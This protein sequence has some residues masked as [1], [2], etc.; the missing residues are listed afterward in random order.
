[1]PTGLNSTELND[2]APAWVS[3]PNGR[4][5]SIIF[6]RRDISSSQTSRDMEYPV[7][8][9]LYSLVMRHYR[10][11][12]ERGTGRGNHSSVVPSERQMG[13]HCHPRP[14]NSTVHGR[15]AMVLCVETAQETQQI[16]CG[17]ADRVANGCYDTFSE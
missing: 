13:Y 3:E 11:S 6:H 15:K 17:R 12:H 9:L 14:G 2:F 4:G 16:R 7:Q 8:L 1:M 10:H 5:L